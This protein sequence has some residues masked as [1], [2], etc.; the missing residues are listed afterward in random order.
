M[1]KLSVIVPVYNC[2]KEIGRCLESIKK[3]TYSNLDIIVVDD[4]SNDGTLEICRQYAC[5]DR[6]IRVFH[7]EN[8]GVIA[9]RRAGVEKAEG[10]YIT[11]VDGD[12][13]I[14]PE[15]YCYMMNP[16]KLQDY[17]IICS[18]L[19]LEKDNYA[20]DEFDGFREGTYDRETIV[21]EIIPCMMYS[22][23]MKKRA[24]TSS[25]CNKVFKKNIVDK[26]LLHIKNE[27]TYGEDAVITYPSIAIS[28]K[29][30]LYT[31]SWYHYM[32][33]D[34]S[35][36]Q[37]YSLDSF[38]KILNL[39]N[40]FQRIFSK[41]GIWEDMKYQVEQYIRP[42]LRKAIKNIYHFD[43]ELITFPFPSD[44]I[45][46]DAKIVLYGGG[47]VGKSFYHYL[48]EIKHA[49]LVLWVDKN[50]ERLGKYDGF[51]I[52]SPEKMKTE[53][54]DYV[55]IAIE[56]GKIAESIKQGLLQCGI[57]EEKVVWEQPVRI[58]SYG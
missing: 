40:E 53:E 43:L 28:R 44:K 29:I 33:H 47:E 25:V 11:F 9:A 26:V 6:R 5:M 55:V 2:R 52:G 34:G 13:W 39:E 50:Y 38:G 45:K 37:S 49:E 8:E 10:E 12:D 7:Q 22:S 30:Y 36:V 51:L 27:I 31:K 16:V 20:A 54:F 48:K 17:D 58:N 21:A 41:F 56:N 4:G 23:P 19:T 57:A 24:V 18:G 14:E 3:Q 46:K 42:F 35:M 32:I 1:K 15:M